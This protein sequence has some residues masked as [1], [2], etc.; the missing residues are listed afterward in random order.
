[1]NTITFI[2]IELG[3]VIKRNTTSSF[4]KF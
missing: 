4:D 1:V 3:F 2:I